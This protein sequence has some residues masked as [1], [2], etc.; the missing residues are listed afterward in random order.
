MR[1]NRQPP[2]LG[3]TLR[4]LAAVW[5]TAWAE[6]LANR[7]S[8]VAQMA[9]MVVNDLVWIFFWQVFFHRVGSVR[10]WTVDDMMVLY[11]VLALAV[12]LVLG[13][14]A[15]LRM[16]G[17][18]VA[19]G[20]IDSALSLPVG[21]LGFL[22]LRQVSPVNVGDIA[23]GIGL[24]AALGHPTPGRTALFLAATAAAVAV[25]VGFLVLLGSL[26]FLPGSSGAGELGLSAIIVFSSYPTDL[27]GG[28]LRL[29]LFGLVP[30]ALVGSVPAQLVQD[31]SPARIALLAGGAVAFTGAGWL[32]FRLGLRRYTSGA[33]WTGM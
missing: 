2:T 14:L 6:A 13:A 25:L 23:F 15:N 30:A 5:R 24:F 3:A 22:A 31:P 17:P 10:G 26:A 16:L 27:F 19:S 12:G 32:S 18:L 1:S 9:V 7:G 28:A 29:A 11:A 4:A 20:D 33:I 21:P 8:F